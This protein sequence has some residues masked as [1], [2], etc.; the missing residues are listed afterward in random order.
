MDLRRKHGRDF[1]IQQGFDRFVCRATLHDHELQ[2]LDFRR[3]TQ[4]FRSTLDFPFSIGI[5]VHR[6]EQISQYHAERALLESNRY[7]QNEGFLVSGEPE[8]VT[9]PLSQTLAVR[10]NYQDMNVTHFARRL[11]IDNANLLRLVGL[12]RS[13]PERPLSAPELSPILGVTLRSTRRILQKLCD[14]GIITPTADISEGGRGRPTH[15]YKFVS[16]ALERALMT[17]DK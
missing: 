12:Y 7:G 13:D 15:R 17:P 1:S 5:G 9:G 6:G 3:I 10:Y 16:E 8:V 14:M 11:G 4:L 2:E